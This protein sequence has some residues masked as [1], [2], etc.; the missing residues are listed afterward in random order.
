MSDPRIIKFS[1]KNPSKLNALKRKIEAQVKARITEN[2]TE[3]R[4]WGSFGRTVRRNGEII[5][6]GFRD[7]RDTDKLGNE[8]SLLASI[9]YKWKGLSLYVQSDN[10][11]IEAVLTGWS[12]QGKGGA[13]VVPGR[14][15]LD[16][17]GE[18]LG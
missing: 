7:I 10:P 6:G 5:Y 9:S 15:F 2:I 17:S 8:E 12:R 4:D 16:L 11:Y 14:D 18:K 1:S 3:A 13:I